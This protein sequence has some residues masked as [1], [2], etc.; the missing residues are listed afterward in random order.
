MSRTNLSG[1]GGR[2]GK[3]LAAFDSIAEYRAAAPLPDQAQR[4]VDQAVIDVQLDRLSITAS[5]MA[6]GL[7][8]NLDNPL[9]VAE[10]YQEK[11]NQT[12]HAKRVMNPSSR[13]ESQL[14]DRSGYTV[15]IYLTMDT[16]ELNIRPLLM[17]RRVG[18]PLDTTLVS[19]AIRRVNESIEDA[20]INGPGVTFNGHTAY[21]LLNEPNVS[22]IAYVSNEAWDAA[23]HDGNDI[24]TDVMAMVAKL[25][26]NKYYGPYKLY[27]PTLYWMKLQD[28]W[29]TNS[30]K[31]IYQRLTELSFNGAPLS[32]EA[33]DTLG[34]NRTIML[35]ASKDVLDLVVGQMPTVVS[36]EDG[37]G[38][39]FNFA[40]MGI[41]IPRIKSTYTGQS[42]IVKGYTS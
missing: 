2:L 30:D 32:I 24:Y 4:V 7:T 15:P 31:T 5:L 1:V 19:Q 37:P 25:Q 39:E 17:S 29:K 34:A 12:G 23:G 35:Q 26:L 18:A 22:S 27:V 6:S 3:R 33:A 14:V 38:W 20:V 21:G 28:D 40:A 8:Y 10:L 9:S 16:F 42:G 36:W 11:I 41:V 13:G